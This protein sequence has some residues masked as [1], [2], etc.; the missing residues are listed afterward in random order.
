MIF[1]IFADRR[2]CAG[3][4]VS[5]LVFLKLADVEFRDGRAQIIRVAGVTEDAQGLEQAFPGDWIKHRV[6]E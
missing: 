3:S 5:K 1:D 6:A 2:N 4:F